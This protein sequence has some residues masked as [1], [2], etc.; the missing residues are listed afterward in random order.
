MQPVRHAL[1]LPNADET[2][3]HEIVFYDWG[4][5]NATQTTICVHGLTRN[6]HD[7][8]LLAAELASRG[9]R[10]LSVSMA[11]R[12]ESAW[13]A[14]PMQYHYGTYVA[15]CLALMD[16][17]HLRGVEWIGTSMGGII[18]IMIASAQPNRIKRLVLNDVGTHLFKASLQRI[19]H[20]V[21]TMPKRFDSRDDAAA[22][23]SEIFAPF[24]ITDPALWDQF[25][26][27]SL[28]HEPDGRVKL[29]CDPAIAVPLARDSKQFTEVH[30][31]NLSQFWESITMPTLILRGEQSDVLSP[32][33]VSAMLSTNPRAESVTI[34][35]VGHAPSLMSPEQ[36][37]LVARWLTSSGAPLVF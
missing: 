2:G 10:V 28:L 14:D 33:T 34:P 9:R 36:I 26:D 31:V 23:L 25:V 18:G 6:A 20:Y 21:S 32:E 8:D 17:F 24:G 29:A 16:N 19:Y 11:G 13:L 12:G 27:H 22:Y 5:P 1:P 37:Q 15:D 30:D 4:N 7:F 35:Y 3:R